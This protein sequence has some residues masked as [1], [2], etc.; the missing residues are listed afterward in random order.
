MRVENGAKFVRR[1][2]AGDKLRRRPGRN[3]Q[4]EAV[5]FAKLDGFLAEVEAN[6]AIPGEVNPAQPRAETHIRAEFS[7]LFQGGADKGRP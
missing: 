5:G 6:R 1:H 4:N 3:R 7:Q 2:K